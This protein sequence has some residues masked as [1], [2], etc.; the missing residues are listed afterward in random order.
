MLQTRSRFPLINF[1][2]PNSSV[3]PIISLKYKTAGDAPVALEEDVKETEKSSDTLVRNTL[4]GIRQFGADTRR[5]SWPKFG[6]AWN[7][8]GRNMPC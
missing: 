1:G 4:L 2:E 7:Y 3:F 8:S 6:Q 5:E